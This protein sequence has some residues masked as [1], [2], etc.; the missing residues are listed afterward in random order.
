LLLLAVAGRDLLLR[1]ALR[2]DAAG[3]VV[4]T[5]LRRRAVAWTE[6]ERVQ[7]VTDRRAPLLELDLGDTLVLLSRLR[8][9]RPPEAVAAELSALQR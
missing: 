3:I 7:V 9:G 6:V 1:P 8:L 5:G 4:V 2:A